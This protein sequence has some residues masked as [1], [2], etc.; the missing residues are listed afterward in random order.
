LVALVLRVLR[1]EMVQ[2]DSRAIQ[3]RPVPLVLLVL[4]VL[5]ALLVLPVPLVLPVLPVL[6]V[7]QE[8]TV[9]L[10]LLHPPLLHNQTYKQYSIINYCYYSKYIY[11]LYQINI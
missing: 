2:M 7:F 8:K 4:P 9:L 6:L 11:F 10:V 5:R 3:A 1:V